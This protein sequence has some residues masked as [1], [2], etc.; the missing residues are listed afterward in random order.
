MMVY[1]TFHV[2]ISAE[3]LMSKVV[4]IVFVSL[5]LGLG[6]AIRGH[7]GHEWGAA[8]AG[9]MA[10]LAV[11]AVSRRGDWIA[12]TPVLGAL[13]G[14]GW[15]VGGMM[16]YGRV[17]GFCRGSYFLD[18]YYGLL[19]LAVV[20]GLYGLIG[21]GLLGLGLETTE[22]RRP[23]WAALI[24]QM[25]AGGI[26][27]WG[28]LV[29]KLEWLMTPPRSEL[30]AACLGAGGALAWYCRRNDFRLALRTAFYSALGAGFGFA[31][32]NF[33]QTLGT[34][35]GISINWWNVMEFTLGS[36]G[37]LGMAYAVFTRPW[38]VCRQA[39]A[40][41]NGWALALVL[42]AIP[43]VNI[44][45]AFDREKLL[46]MAER[47]G[48][49]EPGVFAEQHIQAAWIATFV[50]LILGCAV[51][52]I[53]NGERAAFG[54]LR[55]V[56]LLVVVSLLYIVFSHLRKG[57]LAVGFDSQPEQLVYWVVFLAAGLL[58]V[59]SCRSA[60]VPAT[61]EE[62]PGESGLETG[63]HYLVLLLLLV[64]VCGLLAWISV[65]SHEGLPGAHSRFWPTE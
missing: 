30:W 39:S 6:W 59:V 61:C 42:L 46:E 19:M 49:A 7:F 26:F 8:W 54:R 31:F 29:Y 65:N 16:S 41:S 28:L 12:R 13:A 48:L 64:L 40:S 3:S 50:G 4:A 27:M 23:D 62:V 53:L 24:T 45:Q 34:V 11:V 21:G 9:V 18:V 1:A 52:R 15:A 43:V 55:S 25:V 44:Q 5:T 58:Y 33:L 63:R 47:V 37:G 2:F 36:C 56:A 17:V 57:V 22:R 32:G 51:W 38:P 14:V 10:G 35:S 60:P 20:G